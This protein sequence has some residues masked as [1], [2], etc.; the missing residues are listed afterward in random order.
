MAMVMAGM[1]LMPNKK[2]KNLEKITHKVASGH[3]TCWKQVA[4]HFG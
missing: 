4:P 1:E 3:P 2:V